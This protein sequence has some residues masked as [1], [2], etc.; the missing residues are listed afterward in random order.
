M[1]PGTKTGKD[2]S[3]AAERDRG[4]A[5]SMRPGTKTG[6]DAIAYRGLAVERL[7]FNEARY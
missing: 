2:H 7:S 5:A 6:K 4:P 3:R 1:R